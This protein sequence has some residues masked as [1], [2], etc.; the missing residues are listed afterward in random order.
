M[1][2][3]P[4]NVYIMENDAFKFMHEEKHGVVHKEG[5]FEQMETSWTQ[6]KS[7]SNR[8]LQYILNL[9]PHKPM[10]TFSLNQARTYIFALAQPL[11]R[12]SQQIQVYSII[13]L[14]WACLQKRCTI[15]TFFEFL[16]WKYILEIYICSWF[17]FS[18]KLFW[19]VDFCSLQK[20][21]SRKSKNYFNISMFG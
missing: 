4:D 19:L 2:T 10:D 18:P 12:I 15:Y 7:E 14:Y 9:E 5:E 11:A 21:F 17:C 1:K 13:Y 16:C 6:S 20:Y 3:D 8:L